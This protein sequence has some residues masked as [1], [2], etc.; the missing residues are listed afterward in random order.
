MAHELNTQARIYQLCG[1]IAMRL[2]RPT[3]AHNGIGSRAMT[4]T[5]DRY[6]ERLMSR[7]LSEPSADSVVLL[8]FRLE[9][10]EQCISA[11]SGRRGVRLV[12][13][14][15]FA[16]GRVLGH[17]TRTR[18]AGERVDVLGSAHQ[19]ASSWRIS[20]TGQETGSF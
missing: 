9:T 6:A 7:S 12:Q 13:V 16:S 14:G 20:V 2:P 17:L 1:T 3:A 11:G 8:A 19:P 15:V 10:G 18:D 5:S 4:G